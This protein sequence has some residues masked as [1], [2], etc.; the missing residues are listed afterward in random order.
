MALRQNYDA[1]PRPR[2]SQDVLGFIRVHAK[3]VFTPL[4]T[5][6]FLPKVSFSART[7]PEM[8]EKQN[9]VLES[10]FAERRDARTNVL[11][12]NS[13]RIFRD[14]SFSRKC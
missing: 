12:D 13:S 14:F 7:L 11:S 8:C 9:R 6:T 4:K 3:C 2:V 5:T 10:V 1:F